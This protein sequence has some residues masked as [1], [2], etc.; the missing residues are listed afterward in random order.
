MRGKLSVNSANNA[1]LPYHSHVA[2]RYWVSPRDVISLCN[3]RLD[4]DRSQ[5]CGKNRSPNRPMLSAT[6]VSTWFP[7]L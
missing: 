1:T 6:L 5:L 3:E 2:K 7:W 4:V